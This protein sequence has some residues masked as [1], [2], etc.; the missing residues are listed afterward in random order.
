MAEE[1]TFAINNFYCR[2]K[3]VFASYFVK[4][5]CVARAAS[6]GG[7]EITHVISK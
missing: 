7:A 5:S 6:P 3:A 4:Q 2:I 1:C